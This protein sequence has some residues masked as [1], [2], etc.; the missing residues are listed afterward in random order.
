MST[1]T[2]LSA[3]PIPAHALVILG[4]LSAT[5]AA[6]AVGLTD[7][8]QT[9]CYNGSAMVACDAITTGDSAAYPAQDGRFGRDAAATAG[10]L[11]KT[12][13]GE[14]GF[15]YTRVCNSGELAGA[16]SCPANP[17]LGSGN[18]DWGCTKDNITGLTWEVKIDDATHLRHRDWSYSWYSTDNT[19]NGGYAGT[20]DG[21]DNCLDTTRCDT[22][23]FVTDVNTTGLCGNSDWRMPH[24]NEL[25]TLT[26]YGKTYNSA[27]FDKGY[28][29]NTNTNTQTV[30]FYWS[31]MSLAILDPSRWAWAWRGSSESLGRS[32]KSTAYFV[33]LVRGGQP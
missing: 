18:D 32:S 9:L 13:G 24:I 25:Q 5:M 17:V 7:T 20:P 16:G 8:G 26:H 22:E 11:S 29:P 6:Q 28:F 2:H 19:T 12:G 15:D 21:G 30:M 1:K 31:A 10:Q 3:W 27:L 14:A 33:R 23:K 4:A